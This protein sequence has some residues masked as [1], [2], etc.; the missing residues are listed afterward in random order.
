MADDRCFVD[1]AN[2]V[3][4]GIAAYPS[5]PP[6]LARHLGVVVA[7][8]GPAVAAP[9]QHALEHRRHA[10]TVDCSSCSRL[11]RGVQ[12]IVPRVVVPRVAAAIKRQSRL[13]K[14]VQLCRDQC[15]DTSQHVRGLREKGSGVGQFP[16]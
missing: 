4:L 16:V 15:E 12:P 10:A 14:A 1:A 2:R 9:I 3:G 5:S 8:V 7:A 6:L 11:L 13:P